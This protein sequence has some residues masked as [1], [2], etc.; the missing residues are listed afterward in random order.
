MEET[1]ERLWTMTGVDEGDD[2]V[3]EKGALQIAGFCKVNC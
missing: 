1:S 3:V 2:T